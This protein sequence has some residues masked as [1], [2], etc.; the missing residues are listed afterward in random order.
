ME[1]NNCQYK[2]TF[3]Q[4]NEPRNDY[5][6][7]NSGLNNFS[8]VNQI[9]NQNGSLDIYSVITSIV[10]TNGRLINMNNKIIEQNKTLSQQIK[11][12]NDKIEVLKLQ[13]NLK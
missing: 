10:E 1:F 6:F 4:M 8:P 7:S 13:N 11:A 12:L 2:R 3:K 5:F 9:N